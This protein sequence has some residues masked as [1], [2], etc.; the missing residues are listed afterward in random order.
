MLA[1]TATAMRESYTRAG[2]SVK[3]LLG[4]L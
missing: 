1:A 2:G 3:P 4:R